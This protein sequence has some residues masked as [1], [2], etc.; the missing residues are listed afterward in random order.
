MASSKPNKEVFDQVRKAWVRATPEE[1]VRQHLLHALIHERGFPR[2]WI[3]VEK[4]IGQLPHLSGVQC[5]QRK[6]DILCYGGSPLSPLLLIE[7]KREGAEGDPMAQVVGYNHY[8]G[9]PFMGIASPQGFTWE[10]KGFFIRLS[11]ILRS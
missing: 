8:V 9:A 1:C 7:C 3:V 5:P 11:L 6:I 10:G 2:E 4:E